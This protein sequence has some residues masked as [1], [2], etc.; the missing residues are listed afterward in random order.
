MVDEDIG[1]IATLQKWLIFIVNL[2][3]FLFGLAQIGYAA[4]IL[5]GAGDLGFVKD[6]VGGGNES[7]NLMLG[8]GIA[9]VLISFLGCCGA[10][11]ESK[12]MLWIYAI[13]LFFMMMGQ[14]CSVALIG[15]SVTYGDAIFQSLWK[16]LDADTVD[17]IEQ[18]YKCCSF[19]G[20]NTDDT[21]PEDATDWDECSAANDWEPMQ[22][23][24]G[25]FKAS[26][27]DNYEAIQIFAGAF[28]GIQVL[29]YF[30]THY[31]IKSIANA[32]G[33]EKVK[34]GEFGSDI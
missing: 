15:V 16:E 23:C 30:C 1:C 9:V 5:S 12:C 20:E 19:N 28:L 29:I 18:S 25:K 6:V 3:L 17:T 14:S 34:D 10:Q 2:I 4:Y 8:F 7:V 11:R 33:I 32:E 31:L 22:T 24:W 26:I 27:D 13:V 21:W